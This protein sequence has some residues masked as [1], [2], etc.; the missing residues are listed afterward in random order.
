MV[1][2]A[3]GN[4]SVE[5]IVLVGILPWSNGTNLENTTVDTWNAVLSGIASSYS[6]AVYV[7]AASMVGQFRVGG[8]VG[9]LRDIQPAYDADGV[10]FTPA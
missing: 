4:S 5:K 7:S 10:H 1:T 8:P 9:N 6:K 2:A 3:Q